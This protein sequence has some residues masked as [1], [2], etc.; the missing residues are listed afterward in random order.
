MRV[1]VGHSTHL[2]P[3]TAATGDFKTS[4]WRPH[5]VPFWALQKDQWRLLAQNDAPTAAFTTRDFLLAP[6][7]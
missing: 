5:K 1:N 2:K 6:P 4:S 3:T 7:W